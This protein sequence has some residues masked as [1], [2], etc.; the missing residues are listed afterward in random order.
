MSVQQNSN[1]TVFL[2]SIP[3]FLGGMDSE[4]CISAEVN[5]SSIKWNAILDTSC[6]QSNACNIPVKRETCT[7]HSFS[8]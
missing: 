6:K 7:L 8:N 4:T 1:Y 5:D 2:N 3:E